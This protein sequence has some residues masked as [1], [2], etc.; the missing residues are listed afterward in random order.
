[1]FVFFGIVDVVDL[2]TLLLA[3]NGELTS[4]GIDGGVDMSW[5]VFSAVIDAGVDW[6]EKAGMVVSSKGGNGLAIVSPTVEVGNEWETSALEVTAS[7]VLR[8]AMPPGA[9]IA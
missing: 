4:R 8:V 7:D 3:F 1:V 2:E 5:T 6:V 9:G